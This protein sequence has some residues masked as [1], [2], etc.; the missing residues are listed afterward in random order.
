MNI[1]RVKAT[2][3][4]QLKNDSL[5]VCDGIPTFFKA[6]TEKQIQITPRLTFVN[7][8]NVDPHE[9]TVTVFVSLG[10]YWMDSRVSFIGHG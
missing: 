10:L 1:N 4:C 7:L 9:N 2:T 5:R 3:S 8:A 6:S